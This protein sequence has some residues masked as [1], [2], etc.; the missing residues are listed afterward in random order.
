MATK[1]LEIPKKP[2]EYFDVI[3][4]LGQTMKFESFGNRLLKYSVKAQLTV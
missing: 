1:D 3:G 4:D 2:C